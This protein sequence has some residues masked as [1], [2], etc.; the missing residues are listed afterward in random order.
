MAEEPVSRLFI[1]NLSF[2]VD[3][4]MLQETFEKFGRVTSANIAMRD[5]RSRGFGFVEFEKAEDAEAAKK[6]LQ[7]FELE[8]RPINIDFARPRAPREAGGFRERRPYERRGG[9]GG[10]D[11]RRRDRYGA[12]RGR[13]RGRGYRRDDEGRRGGRDEYED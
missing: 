3:D 7:D 1:G 4:G 2:R 11:D 10:G 8:G 6:E 9:Y 13:D 5:G 12:D